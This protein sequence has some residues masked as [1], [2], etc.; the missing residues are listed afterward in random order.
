MTRFAAILFIAAVAGARGD[1]LDFRNGITLT[2]KFVS[3][4]A[5]EVTF[6]IDGEVK[7]YARSQVSRITFASADSKPPAH[8]KISVGQN[9]DQVTALLGQPTRIVDAGAKKVYI[10]PDLKIT[11]VDGKVTAVE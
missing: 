2:G 9:I 3:I 6:M 8:E 1:T 4:D 5:A 11:F 10:Y 7:S